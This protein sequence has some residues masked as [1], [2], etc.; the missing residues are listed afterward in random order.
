[1][2]N[3]LGLVADLH[4]GGALSASGVRTDLHFQE[5]VVDGE[6][7]GRVLGPFLDHEDVTDYYVPVLV[8]DRPGGAA[9]EELDRLLGAAP[10]PS[11]GRRTALYVCAECGGLGCGAVTAVV[12]VADETVAWRDFGYQN[13]YEPFDQAGVF[14][15]VGPFTFDRTSYTR[16]LEGFRSSLD[17]E[18]R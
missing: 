9:R 12:E 6:R 3:S 5:F 2:G 11:L 1:V 10:E 13:D 7:L 8:A 4:R 17:S 15:G 14:S 18:H 16:V